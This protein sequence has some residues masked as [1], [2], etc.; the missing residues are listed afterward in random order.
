MLFIKKILNLFEGIIINIMKKK[1]LYLLC[2]LSLTACSTKEEFQ[3]FKPVKMQATQSTNQPTN[4]VM[5]EVDNVQFEYKILPHDRVSVVVYE[6]PELSTTTIQSMQQDRGLLVNS[7]GEIR[8]PL[9]KKVNVAGLTQT[10]AEEKV[11]DAFRAYLKYPDIQ[12]EV[13]NKRAYVVGEV[14]RP[15][16]VA[17]VNEQLTLLQALASV[18]DITDF[19]DRKSIMIFKNIQGKVQTQVVNLIDANSLKTAN[20]MIQPNDIIY[21]MPNNMK[22]F[23]VQ[24]N[25]FDP[26]LR[27]VGDIL[28][29][30][31]HIK[32]L[33]K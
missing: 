17:L 33:S 16:E 30:F 2:L 10:E 28:S 9:I 14:Q 26:I 27:L 6:H 29:P 11:S 15:G 3:L 8:L 31:V 18:G 21:V 7:K 1:L 19:A 22:A 20:L 25:Q 12:L 24:V 13:L 23:N 4:G 5:T 32:Y